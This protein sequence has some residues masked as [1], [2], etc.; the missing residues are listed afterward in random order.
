LAVGIVT[1][2]LGI[3]IFGP[4]EDKGPVGSFIAF[5]SVMLF[6]IGTIGGLA[7]FLTGRRKTT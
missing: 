3:A 2:L 4:T 1:V 7:I 6:L 5:F